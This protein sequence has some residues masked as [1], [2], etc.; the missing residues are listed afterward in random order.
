[1]GSPRDG[2]RILHIW[3]TA[4]VASTTAKFLDRGFGTRSVVIAR[5]QFD[6]LGFTTY[7]TAY[8]DGA[9]GFSL[10]AL[11]MSR[12]AD[13]V[14]V[15]AWDRILPWLRRF[16]GSKPLVMYYVGSEI[17]G[18][19]EKKKGRWSKADQVAYTTSDLSEGAPQIA[20]QAFCP[21][22]TDLFHPTGETRQPSSAVSIRYGMEKETEESCRR[23]GLNLKLID[24]GSVPYSGMPELFSK[25][26]YFIDMRKPPGRSVVETLGKAGLEALASGC[27][28]VDWLGNVHEGLPD[29][30]RPEKAAAKWYELY[31]GLMKS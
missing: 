18:R 5:K 31:Q 20:V 28:V 27:K 29:E 21:I 6:K 22:D 1:M 25:Y 4:G 15:Y 13:I 7:G 30:N 26:E 17:R 8:N 11:R 23:L 3:N 19:W 9:L 14:Q 24:R 2:L 16:S 12:S 10:R